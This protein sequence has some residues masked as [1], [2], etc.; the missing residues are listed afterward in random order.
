MPL[1]L[2]QIS[3]IGDTRTGGTVNRD[4][5]R[6]LAERLAALYG[7][8]HQVIVYEASPFP[9]GRPLIEPC[10]VRALPDAGVTGLSTLYVPPRPALSLA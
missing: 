10:A 1:I 3:V 5:L 9:V 8:D 4:G 6:V 2:W 7:E